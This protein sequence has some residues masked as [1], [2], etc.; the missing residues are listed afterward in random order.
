LP[1]SLGIWAN[2]LIA[3]AALLFVPPLA[4]K[5]VGPPAPTASWIRQARIAGVELD[6]SMTDRQVEGKLSALLKQNVSVVEADS[7]L[8]YYLDDDKFERELA[9]IRRVSVVAHRLGLRI[10]WY[11]PVLEVLSPNALKGRPS[12]FKDHPDAVQIGLNGKP[13]VFYGNKVPVHW[14]ERDTE[15]A[16]ISM[17]SPYAETLIER[18]K[19]VAATGVDGLWLDVPLFNDIA[20]D[21][22]DLSPAAAAKFETDTGLPAPKELNWN[23]PTWRRWISWRYGEITNF[24][25]RIASAA[26][27]TTSDI[28]IIVENS[29]IDHNASTMLGL[30]GSR[31][32]ANAEIIQVWEVDVLSDQAGMAGAQPDDWISMIGM[33]KFAKAASGTKP[34]WM[35]TYGQIPSDGELVMAAAIAAGNH[36]YETKAPTMASSIGLKYRQRTFGWVKDQER[37]LFE[38]ASAAKVA[39]YYS[40]ESRDYVDKAGGT[41]LYAT[42]KA[43]DRFWWSDRPADSLNARTYLADYRGIIKWMVQNHVPFDIV[44]R[45]DL[46]ELGR[47]N[48]VIAPSL[49]AISNHDAGLLD[50]YVATGGNLL[51]TG[52]APTMLDELG[53]ERSA[54][55]LKLLGR[56]RQWQVSALAALSKP[57]GALVHAPELLGKSYL[58]FQSSGADATIRELVAR[59]SPSPIQTDASPSIHMELRTTGNETLLHLVNPERLW[60]KQAFR[61]RKIAINL[62]MPPDL[63]AVGVQVTSPASQPKM[64]GPVPFKIQGDRVLFKVS[65]DAYAMVVISSQ[66]RR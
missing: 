46:E 61:S 9:L 30:E 42:I 45:P 40:P 12:M 63:Q 54:P 65:L 18:I 8:S 55:A 3:A 16:W 29:T 24:V 53:S 35:F 31:F 2:L 14:V 58:A 36:P 22:S 52:P 41:G 5:E 47:Y 59:Y 57:E 1:T 21:W 17:Y 33:T 37:R 27:S 32:K 20:T 49:A 60:N 23:D 4:A 43:K 7:N 64:T 6:P 44:V 15:S 51:L 10:V 25:Q 56:K 62:K 13:N 19:K 26:K 39:I 11:V 66:L 48:L 28:A 50:E 38:S 34:S